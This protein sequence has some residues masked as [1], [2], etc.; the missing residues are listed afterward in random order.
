VPRFRANLGRIVRAIG[1]G[2]LSDAEKADIETR[3]NAL[4]AWLNLD[5]LQG[6]YEAD[7]NPAIQRLLMEVQTDALDGSAKKLAEQLAA[8]LG[9]VQAAGQPLQ[10]TLA[11][12][13]KYA[14]LQLIWQ[15]RQDKELVALVDAYDAS[16]SME[17]VFAL[18]DATAWERV[19]Q[20]ARSEAFRFVAPNADNPIRTFEPTHFEIEPTKDSTL[21]QTFLFM[22]RLH[23]TWE[24]M[25]SPEEQVRSRLTKA[26]VGLLTALHLRRK[27]KPQP[28]LRP[29]SL[30]PR[31]MQ[32][33]PVAGEMAIRVSIQYKG[34]T[35]EIAGPRIHVDKSEDFL[36][37]RAFEFAEMMALGIAAAVAVVTGLE[38]FYLTNASFGSAKDYVSLFLWGAGVDVTKTFVQQLQAHSRQTGASAGGS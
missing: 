29:V 15:R 18:A 37:R 38:T 12:E 9:T 1:A 13:K 3:L 36:W 30:E 16:G 19:K 27:P 24:L 35:V 7:V 2:P 31:V 11:R 33:C 28:P 6:L 17:K 8:D 10:E 22:H 21:K 4:E 34:E 14:M 20:E 23:F 26:L 32:F 5:T 25:I